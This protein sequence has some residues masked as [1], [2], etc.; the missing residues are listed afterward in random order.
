MLY[1]AFVD[2]KAFFL[3]GDLKR[4]LAMRNFPVLQDSEASTRFEQRVCG[5]N[6]VQI[7]LKYT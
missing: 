5:E 4:V 3:G 6:A 1:K 7:L 2:A